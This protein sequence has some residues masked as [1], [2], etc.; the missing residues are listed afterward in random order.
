MVVL[1]NPI[2]NFPLNDDWAY[3]WTVKNLLETGHFQLADWTATN[4]LPQALLGTLFS[5]PFGF[6]FTALRL[7]TLLM[8]LA[9]V[10]TTYGL[11]R[12]ARCSPKIALFGSLV[13]ALNPIYFELSNTFNTD[14][15]SF[16]FFLVSVYFLARGLRLASNGVI[17]TGLVFAFIAILNRQSSVI[18]LPA[19]AVSFLICRGLTLRTF[20]TAFLVLFI[21]ITV[22]AVYSYWLDYTKQKP[23]L[24]GFQIEKLRATLAS[25]PGTIATTYSENIWLFFI[26]GGLFLFPF[27]VLHF[28]QQF[29]KYSFLQKLLSICFTLI[30]LTIGLN[31]IRHQKQM[32]LIGNSLEPLGLGPTFLAGYDSF[33]YENRY[34]QLL[35]RGWWNLLT[36]TGLIGASILFQY[37]LIVIQHLHKRKDRLNQ[38]WFA[39]LLVVCTFLYLLPIG[40]LSKH[41]WFDR[42][43]LPPLPLLMTSIF[44]MTRHFHQ[45]RKFSGRIVV[46]CCLSLISYGIYA[47]AATHDYLQQNRVRWLAL[48]DLMRRAHVSPNQIGGGF[49]FNGWHHAGARLEACN[50]AFK[51]ISNIKQ[52]DW[53]SFSCLWDDPSRKYTI[54]FTP[55]PGYQLKS[56]Y[57]FRRWLPWSIQVLYVLQKNK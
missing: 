37:L 51:H 8:G 1:V 40:G 26:Y 24:Y 53:G 7:S 4:L 54:A 32:P 11:L 48:N 56:R 34:L 33:F 16:T 23:A 6:S 17:L 35:V 30:L 29:R 46:F 41:F 50:P 43:L 31:L 52:I 21:G 38:V 14:I 2:G 12:E 36:L 19:L 10:I 3:G 22:Y 44:L 20:I 27:L 55:I 49:E 5:L 18:I 13:I 28:S 15:H 45:E 9:G 42:Y 57:T 47:V 25:G 39:F